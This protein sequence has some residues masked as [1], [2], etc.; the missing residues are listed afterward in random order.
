MNRDLIN[1]R[2]IYPFLQ[3]YNAERSRQIAHKILLGRTRFMP[4][5]PKDY[6][7]SLDARN[8]CGKV[9]TKIA[10]RYHLRNDDGKERAVVKEEAS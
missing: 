5:L 7:I 6:Y 8:P 1:K 3:N 2:R 4:A 10:R 9:S